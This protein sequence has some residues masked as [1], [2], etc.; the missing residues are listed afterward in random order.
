MDDAVC[1]MFAYV[2]LLVIHACHII[3]THQKFL[4]IK[5]DST[6][7]LDYFSLEQEGICGISLSLCLSHAHACSLTCITLLLFLV[8]TSMHLMINMMPCWP[9][10]LTEGV[11][12]VVGELRWMVSPHNC[13]FKFL[14]AFFVSG[15]LWTWPW[16]PHETSHRMLISFNM[17]I[18][19]VHF[20]GKPF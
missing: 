8:L 17:T 1:L 13:N 16:L 18:Q 10:E 5:H 7:V 9:N 11:V 4:L 20:Q 12:L 14:V 2:M 3:F 19:N 15:W 6:R